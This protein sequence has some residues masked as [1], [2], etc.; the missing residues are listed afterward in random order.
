MAA[1]IVIMRARSFLMAV[2]VFNG[3]STLRDL[4][5]LTLMEESLPMNSGK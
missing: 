3:L 2:T 5:P 4:S 1:N